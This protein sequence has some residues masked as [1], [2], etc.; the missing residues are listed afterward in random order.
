MT[1]RDEF[2]KEVKETLAK[3]VGTLC[4]NPQ[5]STPT[6]GPSDSPSK[7][8]S[9][10]VAGHMKAAAE[11]GPRYDASM[12]SEDRKSIQNG[13]WL[14]E[15]CAKLIDTDEAHYPVEVLER[16][17]SLAEERAHKALENP[18]IVNFGPDFADTFLLVTVQ[19]DS[20]WPS[21]SRHLGPGESARRAITIKPIQ[22]P[23]KLFDANLPITLAKEVA[24][25]GFCLITVTWQNQ[26]TGVDQYIKSDIRFREGKSGKPA[27]LT[28][29]LTGSRIHLTGGLQGSSYASFMIRELLPNESMA[30]HIVA[31]ADI[32]FDASL[33]TQNSRQSPEVFILELF[34]GPEEHV[35]TPQWK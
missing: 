5:C 19:R 27:I 7:S 20:F 29:N 4:S 30:G 15:S 11:G 8:L 26:G 12:S 13:I 21:T 35:P 33:W 28:T 6:Y 18:R 31:R 24:P 22:A 3:R 34:F 17:K 10:G 1:E 23:R 2:S 9:K 32:G 25:P 16:W 14:C